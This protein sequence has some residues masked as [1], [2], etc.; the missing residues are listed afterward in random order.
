MVAQPHW[1]AHT[2]EDYT[3][4]M[5][6][7]ETTDNASI[8]V[9]GEIPEELGETIALVLNALIAN[10]DLVMRISVEHV[11]GKANHF[12]LNAAGRAAVRRA[13]GLG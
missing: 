6:D 4:V 1:T 13:W 8:R 3:V 10:P 9:F 7:G 12:R 11:A 2:G 5:L